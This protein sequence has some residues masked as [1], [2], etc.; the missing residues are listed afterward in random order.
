MGYYDHH[1]LVV[2]D[3]P[4][5]LT[6]FLGSQVDRAGS[7]LAARM[8]LPCAQLDRLVE[9][10][11]GMSLA[12]LWVEKGRDEAARLEGE[13]LARAL[14]ERPCGVLVL[15]ASTLLDPENRRRVREGG[16][17]VYAARP[18]EALYASIQTA[19]EESPAV[20]PEFVLTGPQDEQTLVPL[21][22]ERESGYREA[23]IQIEAGGLTPNGLASAIRTRL[24]W[25]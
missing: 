21:L 24:G 5:C 14:R 6:G 22:A 23:E 8:G 15:G 25:D 18:L 17:L 13:Q 12:R 11:A 2:L 19:R 9:H 7:L 3:Q 4:V 20:F 16:R 10:A 1:P